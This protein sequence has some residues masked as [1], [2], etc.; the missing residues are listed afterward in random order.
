MAL[1]E[2]EQVPVRVFVEAF[3][4]SNGNAALEKTLKIRGIRDWR[5]GS[6][7]NRRMRLLQSPALPLGYPA[8]P[9]GA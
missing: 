4:G 5:R 3:T 8:I 1:L 7:S 2:I 6:E 9:K